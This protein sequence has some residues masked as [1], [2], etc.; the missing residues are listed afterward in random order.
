[1]TWPV[2]CRNCGRLIMLAVAVPGDYFCT[3]DCVRDQI[4]LGW[5]EAQAVRREKLD[6]IIHKLYESAEIAKSRVSGEGIGGGNA[7]RTRGVR[8]R[9]RQGSPRQDRPRA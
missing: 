1:M 7:D 4:E 3:V 8:A 2:L 6:G 5:L 9:G